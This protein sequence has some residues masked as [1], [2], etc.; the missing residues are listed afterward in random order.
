MIALDAVQLRRPLL[1]FDPAIPS[2][3]D[4]RPYPGL[5]RYG[6]F[7]TGGV[8][9]R[10]DSLLLVFP[11][12][13][14]GV[15]RE[16][17]RAV[18]GGIGN[19]PGFETMF[20]VPLSE[21]T[22]IVEVEVPLAPGASR[23]AAREAYRSTMREWLIAPARAGVDLALVVVPESRAWETDSAYYEAK[24]LLSAA[25][26]P[27]QMVT[28][29]LAADRERL[30]WSVANLALAAFVKLGGVPWVVDVPDDERDLVLGVGRGDLASGEG[31][32]RTFGYAVSFGSDGSY[33]HTW[34]F[35]PAASRRSYCER[36]GQAVLHALQD[37]ERLAQAPARLVFHFARRIGRAEIAA[38]RAAI[39]G[40]GATLPAAFVRID[41][42]NLF[43]LLD[44]TS[45]RLVPPQGVMVRLDER[46]ALLQSEGPGRLA[47]PRGPLLIEL[48][49]RSDVGPEAL[50]G[51]VEQIMRLSAANW[52][53]F[54]ARSKPVTLVYGE[55]LAQL[56]AQLERVDSWRSET[57]G[58]DIGRR[59]WFL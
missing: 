59:P 30:T 43:D 6:P 34:S 1:R 14:A 23:E 54:N 28:A 53:G 39:D 35:T 15:A 25:G 26:V 45:A 7:D 55:R 38:I 57:L 16:L 20:R 11:A 40:S 32:R 48:D 12:R 56:V 58:T 24:A 37:R 2:Q 36:L 21:A 19:Y 44:Y 4:A 13:L 17:A 10:D 50:E 46:T 8:R 42:S 22:A 9:I 33:R 47:P 29:E 27:T 5:R 51:L 3:V 31:G 41:D 52:R 18:I 49:R